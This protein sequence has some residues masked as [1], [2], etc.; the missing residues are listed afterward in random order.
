MQKSRL[1]IIWIMSITTC[2]LTLGM[3]SCQEAEPPPEP[4]TIVFGL[5]PW[6]RDHF[7]PLIEEFKE[8]HPEITIELEDLP[9][10][11]DFNVNDYPKN[12][13][14]TWRVL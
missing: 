14:L 12:F 5:Y 4:A 8:V 6:E 10:T 13:C 3:V 1:R 2:L 9:I 7:E 11:Q